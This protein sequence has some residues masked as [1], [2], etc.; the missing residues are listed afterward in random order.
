M[1]WQVVLQDLQLLQVLSCYGMFVMR[2]GVRFVVLF[3]Q[4]CVQVGFWF[5]RLLP[6]A[7]LKSL[8]DMQACGSSLRTELADLWTGTVQAEAFRLRCLLGAVSCQRTRLYTVLEGWGKALRHVLQ[9]DCTVWTQIYEVLHTLRVQSTR[10]G[11]CLRLDFQMSQSSLQLMTGGYV[12][13]GYEPALRL[14]PVPV[15]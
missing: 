1:S 6:H 4:L 9:G 3:L 7:D 2:Q 10:Q 14:L 13:V 5:V 11:V 8:R 15:G 12:Q